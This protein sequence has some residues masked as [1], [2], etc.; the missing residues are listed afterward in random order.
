MPFW[1]EKSICEKKFEPNKDKTGRFVLKNCKNKF[2]ASKFRNK[3][4]S[5]NAYLLIYFSATADIV[6][7][8]GYSLCVCVANRLN[9]V[10]QFIASS[11]NKNILGN[12]KKVDWLGFLKFSLGQTFTRI[13]HQ[14]LYPK[15][16]SCRRIV[17][18][19]SFERLFC[20]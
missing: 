2:F 11:S 8:D 12:T 5:S 3:K 10:A 18:N 13:A 20:L 6:F 14:S 19:Y 16:G 4:N 15:V 9:V 7:V 1:L 17:L